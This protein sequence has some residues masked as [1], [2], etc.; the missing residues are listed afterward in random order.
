MAEERKPLVSIIYDDLVDAVKGIT[1]NTFLGRPK[2]TRKEL[3]KF[4][5]IELPTEIHGMVKGSVDFSAK[6]YGLF[7]IFCK[8]KSDETLNV[9]EQ[10][11][12]AQSVIDKFPIN[13]KY[14]TA[15]DPAVLMKGS[16]GNGFQVT[17]VTFRLRTKF[18]ST[19]IQDN[20]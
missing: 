12:L 6:C 15:T 1:P 19:I 8:S 18:N 16:D 2:S 9:N 4:I 11:A 13:G 14:I 10:S 5:V 17:E 3:T 7:S 20:N